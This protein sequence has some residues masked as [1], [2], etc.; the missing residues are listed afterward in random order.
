MKTATIVLHSETDFEDKDTID[1][2]ND[3][4]TRHDKNNIHIVALFPATEKQ[5]RDFIN[6]VKTK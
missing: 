2:L 3:L 4:A 6:K 5:I 1:C